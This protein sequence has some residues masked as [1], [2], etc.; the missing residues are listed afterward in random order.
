MKI[1]V[2]LCLVMLASTACT[3]V[4]LTPE[5]EKV[6]VLAIDEVGSCKKLGTTTVSLRA[7]VAGFERGDEKVKTELEALA[8]NRAIDLHGDTVVPFSDVENGQQ[9][10]SVYRCVNP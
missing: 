7:K 4:K 1:L 9:T 6:R 10:F 5:G 2:L 8:R 3:W